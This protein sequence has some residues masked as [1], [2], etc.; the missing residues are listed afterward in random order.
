MRYISNPRSLNCGR[1]K[2]IYDD[3]YEFADNW[4]YTTKW[5]KADVENKLNR[6]K[7][8]YGIND[9]ELNKVLAKVN[10]DF[11][12][13][14]SVKHDPY[15]DAVYKTSD[16]N[17]SRRRLNSSKDTDALIT[18]AVNLQPEYNNGSYIRKNMS[19][20]LYYFCA[21]LMD[22]AYKT[23]DTYGYWVRPAFM[24]DFGGSTEIHESESNSVLADISLEDE[25]EYVVSLLADGYTPDTV[26]TELIDWYLD[27]ANSD[28]SRRTSV[29]TNS[30]RRRLNSNRDIEAFRQEAIKLDPGY[31]SGNYILDHISDD[32][33]YFCINLIQR[34][35]K[36][37]DTYGLAV[38]P[39]YMDDLGHPTEIRERT[40]GKVLAEI[41]LED[42]LETVLA[43][44][45]DGYN[46]D[47]IVSELIDWYLD[48]ANANF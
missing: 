9:T 22:R 19:D 20:D 48:E 25:L 36:V 14:K 42:E 23:L 13:K 12:R 16:V 24:D 5:T 4:C 30:S 11:K 15:S 37:V 34:A 35:N 10:K 38:S 1:D 46:S 33:Y 3:L 32:L 8:M 21:N 6:T 17:S 26:V 47:G 44:L 29:R 18:E 40:T 31:N 28:T 2:E 43:M 27:K 45:C 7:R 41:P 39:A